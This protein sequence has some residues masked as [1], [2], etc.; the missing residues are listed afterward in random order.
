MQPYIIIVLYTIVARA[1]V[2]FV[3][4]CVQYIILYII[5]YIII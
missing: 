1:T 2:V 3:S 5:P 4:S